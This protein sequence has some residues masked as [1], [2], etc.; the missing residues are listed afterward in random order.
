M[1]K[2][3]RPVNFISNSTQV[4]SAEFS[5]RC[6]S[7]GPGQILGKHLCS[8]GS[9]HS[10]LIW[11]LKGCLSVSVCVLTSRE[12]TSSPCFMGLRLWLHG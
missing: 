1:L 8:A 12:G 9:A 10:K 3:K 7:T 4:Q 5:Q 2:F 6:W 11:P